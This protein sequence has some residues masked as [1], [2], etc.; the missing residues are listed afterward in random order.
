MYPTI[1]D[2]RPAYL[3]CLLT[4]MFLFSSSKMCFQK[5]KMGPLHIQTFKLLSL[6]LVC[7]C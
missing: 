1:R 6:R 4:A 5:T 2:G 7:T 3:H